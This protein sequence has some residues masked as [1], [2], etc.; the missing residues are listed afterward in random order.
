MRKVSCDIRYYS[1]GY[2]IAL[3]KYH[4][5][6]YIFIENSNYGTYAYKQAE[7]FNGPGYWTFNMLGR[8]LN[9]FC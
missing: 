6:L 5:A 4:V 1:K 8:F 9:F 2:E 7:S 3:I